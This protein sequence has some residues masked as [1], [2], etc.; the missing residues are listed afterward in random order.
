MCG[1]SKQKIIHGQVYENR[2]PPTRNIFPACGLFMSFEYL[3]IFNINIIIIQPENVNT[4][5]DPNYCA[6]SATRA[7]SAPWPNV[8]PRNISR[9]KPLW[10]NWALSTF[11]AFWIKSAVSARKPRWASRLLSPP[12]PQ[13]YRIA[14]S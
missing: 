13:I 1:L 2:R 12:T 8:L 9:S 3:L 7:A 5:E 10:A 14:V 11:R 4:K 6:S